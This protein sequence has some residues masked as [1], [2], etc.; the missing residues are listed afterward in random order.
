MSL[1]S[2]LFP[3]KCM[4]CGEILPRGS[5]DVCQRCMDEVLLTDSAPKKQDGAFFSKVVSALEYE[6]RVR[7]ALHRFKFS[8]RQ[9][10]AAPL[11][12]ILLFATQGKLDG[13][14][15]IIVPVPTNRENIRKRGYNHAALLAG[16]MAGLTGVPWCEALKK[17]RS[18]KPMFG[19]KAAE[20]RANVLGAFGLACPVEDI[21]GK[22]VLVVD[23]VLTT[24]ST[25]SE[26]A[27]ILLESG[28]Q[29]VVCAT[30][31]MARQRKPE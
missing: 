28:A 20:R 7:K 19:L 8:G 27:R 6:G 17:T 1:L 2:L 29:A 12:R 11:A 9:S 22:R 25:L 15:D 10:Y 18:T 13:Q 14:Y 21:A 16:E 5:Q 24:G 26:C 30:V 3:P 4:F 31:A 23:D